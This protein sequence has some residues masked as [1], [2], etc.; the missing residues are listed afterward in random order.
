IEFKFT[1]DGWIE[2][3]KEKAPVANFTA[4]IK[5]NFKGETLSDQWQWSVFQHPRFEVKG[6]TLTLSA[7]PTASYVAQ[8]TIGPD[9]TA[10]VTVMNKRSNAASGLGIIGDDRNMVVAMHSG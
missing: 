8:K 9:Y 1:K 10:T 6:G 4:S 7:T 3:I 2:F 5:D